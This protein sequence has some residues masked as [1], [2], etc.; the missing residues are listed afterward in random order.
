MR[1]RAGNKGWHRHGRGM[2][3]CRFNRQPFIDAR[4]MVVTA[5][6]QTRRRVG[7]ACIGFFWIVKTGKQRGKAVARG[8][9]IP[10]SWYD[11]D[12]PSC[13]TATA[14]QLP[15]LHRGNIIAGNILKTAMRC[16]NSLSQ[17]LGTTP[18]F[19]IT[20]LWHAASL[21]VQNG[22]PAPLQLV[23][24]VSACLHDCLSGWRGNFQFAVNFGAGKYQIGASP[25][26]CFNK[27]GRQKLES[28]PPENPYTGNLPEGIK[29]LPAISTQICQRI[30]C[31][32]TRWM[33]LDEGGKRIMDNIAA[34]RGIGHAIDIFKRPQSQ[35]TL[36]ID[37][38]GIAD[39]GINFGGRK[40]TRAR[41]YRRTGG[42]P[43]DGR[44]QR[45]RIKRG[46]SRRYKR[47]PIQHITNL[48]G[49]KH[50]FKT[51]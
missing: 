1:C 23:D 29:I 18:C 8:P 25:P 12:N 36:C 14:G 4:Q 46:K 21:V 5:I 6:G 37:A 38:V 33:F 35:Y 41:R 47:T 30:I 28:R 45:H 34:Q 20:N 2:T 16:D 39:P 19:N 32:R 9:G 51:L 44:Q 13:L 7:K 22:Q 24:A 3:T 26:F 31:Q 10:V 49:G 48:Q 17:K 11:I 27:P 15:I 43:A 42:R 50:G 40:R